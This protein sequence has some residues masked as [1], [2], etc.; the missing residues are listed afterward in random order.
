M[1]ISNVEPGCNRGR[2]HASLR[3]LP[4]VVVPLLSVWLILWIAVSWGAGQDDALIHLRYAEFLN[5][6]HFI[7][8]DGV[9]RSYGT[10]SLLYVGLLALLRAVTS[11][12]LLPCAVSATTHVCLF[13]VSSVVYVRAARTASVRI[14]LI[15]LSI[16]L[17]MVVPSA[18]RWLGDGMETGIV[19]GLVGLVAWRTHRLSSEPARQWAGRLPQVLLGFL[20]VLLRPDLV[21]ISLFASGVLWAS[22][23][24]DRDSRWLYRVVR[25]IPRGS[26]FLAGSALAQTAILLAMHSA[27]PDTAQAKSHGIHEFF[28]TLSAAAQVIG[29]ALTFGVGTLALWILSAVVVLSSRRTH[30]MPSLFAN[31]VFPIVILA[32]ALR[33]QS[34]Q[35]FRYFVWSLFFSIV[36]NVCELWRVDTIDGEELQND[37]G[38]R[39]GAV[40]LVAFL[41]C[42][43]VALPLESRL[44]LRVFRTRSQTMKLF[45]AQDLSGPIQGEPGVAEDVGYISYFTQAPICDLSGLVNGRFAASLTWQQRAVRCA[46]ERPAFAFFNSTQAR[47][48][49][50]YLDFTGWRVCGQ[51][52]FGNMRSPDRHFLLVSPA[53]VDAVCHA[54]GYSPLPI[55]V[56]MV[57]SQYPSTN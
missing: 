34:I 5:R 41:G 37:R 17:L 49:L 35:G 33:G 20:L 7:T 45:I 48:Y 10:S 9:H 6:V 12:P 57:E 2:V 46:A 15:A 23:A 4:F 24:G 44:M 30:L 52:D 40:A 56:A 11:S 19:V 16:L 43:L 8:F 50:G 13:L 28:P 22:A 21:I 26:D 31:A 54:T 38:A 3:F 25:A 47:S 42:C 51:Y 1:A 55:S 27:L 32:S 14:Q 18:D 36:W 39:L 53:D 29:G